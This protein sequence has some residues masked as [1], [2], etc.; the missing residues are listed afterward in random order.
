MELICSSYKLSD[1]EYAADVAPLAEAII[2]FEIYLKYLNTSVPMF[3][4]TL[5]Q[6]SVK[7]WGGGWSCPKPDLTIRGEQL[8][9][10]FYNLGR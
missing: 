3:V 2:E 5:H 10:M 7:C 6:G 9:Q 8:D 1:T 4:R